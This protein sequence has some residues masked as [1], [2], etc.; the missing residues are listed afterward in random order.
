M[1]LQPH[2]KIKAR[3]DEC[4]RLHAELNAEI[5]RLKA[6]LVEECPHTYLTH[7]DVDFP[8]SYLDRAETRRYFY[9]GCCGKEMRPS[10]VIYTGGYG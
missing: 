10:K 9:C 1:T 7:K 6:A 3:L 4:N 8:G 5:A 2:E